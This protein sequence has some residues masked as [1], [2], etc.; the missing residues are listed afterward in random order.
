MPSKNHLLPWSDW[1]DFILPILMLT[2]QTH[3][4][5]KSGGF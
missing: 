5:D 4:P 3:T 1:G 2:L